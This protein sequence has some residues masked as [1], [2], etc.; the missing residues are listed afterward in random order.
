MLLFTVSIKSTRSTVGSRRLLAPVKYLWFQWQIFLLHMRKI[1][2][3]R[4]MQLLLTTLPDPLHACGTFLRCFVS[5]GWNRLAV[6]LTKL[7]TVI[8]Y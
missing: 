1:Q 2:R 5:A 4:R 8:I 7:S 6:K 3:M